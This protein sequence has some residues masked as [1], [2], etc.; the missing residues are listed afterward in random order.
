MVI[1]E[2]ICRHIR[3]ERRRLDRKARK[4]ASKVRYR[5]L[6]FMTCTPQLTE[7]ERRIVLRELAELQ[8]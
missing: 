8:S 2:T 7:T 1:T 4:V 6:R 5:Q 3:Q